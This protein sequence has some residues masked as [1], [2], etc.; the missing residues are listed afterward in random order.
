MCIAG[1]DEV[2]RG[3]LAGPVVASAV[4]LPNRIPFDGIND[5]KKLTEKQRTLLCSQL[6]NCP[7]IKIGIG[8]VSE[9]VIDRINILQATKRAMF[10]AVNNLPEKPDHLLIDGMLVDEIPISQTKIIKGDSR[11][12]SIAAASI[13]AKVIRDTIMVQFDTVCQGYGFAR[14]KGYGTKEHI[15]LLREKGVSPIHRRSFA[16]VSAILEDN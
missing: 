1:L 5:S 8:M 6:F 11:S 3:P 2:G 7:D 15:R 13:V 14:H 16:P 4:V 10:E 9:R 12:M